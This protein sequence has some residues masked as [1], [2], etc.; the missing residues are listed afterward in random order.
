MICDLH[1]PGM[2]GPETVRYLRTH[3][4]WINV[5]VL[6]ASADMALAY[7]LLKLGVCQYLLKP[8]SH[9]RLREVIDQC[10]GQ[11]QAA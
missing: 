7:D 2:G 3:Y 5:I 4:P 9:D 1:M 6:T 11:I 8:I 10:I